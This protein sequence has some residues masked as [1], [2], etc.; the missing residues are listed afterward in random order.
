M[1]IATFSLFVCCLGWLFVIDC[2]WGCL[3]WL[4]SVDLVVVLRYR[5]V[6]TF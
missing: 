2:L 5:Y 3:L 4:I 1:G 6:L